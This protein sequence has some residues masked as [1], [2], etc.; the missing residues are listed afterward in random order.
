[1]EIAHAG[2][3]D[4]P[5]LGTN[6]GNG[7]LFALFVVTALALWIGSSAYTNT[8]LFP[9]VT[10]QFIWSKSLEWG[11]YKHPPLTT[12]LFAGAT[13]VF[14]LNT[15]VPGVLSGACLAVTG[16]LTWLIAARVLGRRAA[17]YCLLLWSLQQQFSLRAYMYN[18]NVPLL[19]CVALSVWALLEACA[20]PERTRGW[21]LVGV[22]V[23][24]AMMSKYQAAIPL[25]GA[26]WALWRTG[27]LARPEVRRGLLWALGAAFIVC[28]PHLVWLQTSHGLPFQY[29]S[30]HLEHHDLPARLSNASKFAVLQL[31]TVWVAILCGL[32]WAAVAWRSRSPVAHDV[33]DRPGMDARARRA[34]IQGLV[35]LPLAAVLCTAVIGGA[36]LQGQWGVQTLQFASLALVAWFTARWR[37]P[38][39][40]TALG[41]AFALHVLGVAL[42]TVEGVKQ[43]KGTALTGHVIQFGQG[44]VIADSISRDW[45]RV[46]GCPLRYVVGDAHLAGLVSAYSPEHPSALEDGEFWKNPWITPEKL[47][48]AGSVIIATRADLLP[49]NAI[50]TP[51]MV[52]PAVVWRREMALVWGIVPP[53]EACR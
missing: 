2:A 44:Q 45:H 1:M 20:R 31:R 28:L 22:A 29:A 51:E 30:K 11:Y 36:H 39:L 10:E 13:A 34:W 12:W 25:T 15:W 19:M 47:S 33:S 9:D 21:V 40:G 38:S 35:L 26:L 53:T 24:L 14:G 4:R 41:I 52:L 43:S 46:T 37:F 42:V 23:G 3:A 48:A 18:H 7:W 5:A 6:A 49:A 8:A 50:H 16:L 27:Q 32:L 17:F